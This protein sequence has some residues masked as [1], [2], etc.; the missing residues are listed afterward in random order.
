MSKRPLRVT[1][2]IWLVLFLTAWNGLRLWTAIAWREVLVD[3]TVNPAPILTVLSGAVW[4]VIG[5][6]LL[7]NMLQQKARSWK[8]LVLAASGY[9]VWYWIERLVWQEPRPNWPFAVI[10]NLFLILFILS[11]KRALSREM[12]ERKNENPTLE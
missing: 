10:L 6:I 1:L 4:C 8:M 12:Y 7:W 2:S 3:F 9:S 5:C 11:T